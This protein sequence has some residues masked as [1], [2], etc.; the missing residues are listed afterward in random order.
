MRKIVLLLLSSFSVVVIQAQVL[1]NFHDTSIVSQEINFS[2]FA[3]YGAT[4]AQNQLIDKF[5]FGGEITNDIKDQSLNK[6]DRINRIGVS[7]LAEFEYINYNI[8]PIKKKDW[9][10]II[11]AGTGVF[12]GVF[13]SKDL[14]QLGMY[15]NASFDKP[16]IDLTGTTIDISVFQK[17]GFGMIDRKSKSRIAI[18]L[19]NISRNHKLTTRDASLT[20]SE[21]ESQLVLQADGTFSTRGNKV[22][23]QGLGLGLDLDFRIPI[24]N[25]KG[26]TSFVQIKA[27]NMGVGFIYQKQKTYKLDNEFTY[28]GFRFEELL[29]ENGIFSESSTTSVLD[30]IGVEQGEKT[31][32]IALPGYLQI[33]KIVDEH[34][35]K[36][37][38]SFFGLRVHPTSTYLPYLFAGAHFKAARWFDVGLNL[39]YGGFSELRG[40]VYTAF[41][42]EKLKFA[43][44]TED[45]LGLAWKKGRGRSL[46]FSLKCAF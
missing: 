34:S 28:Q 46:Y 42:F 35:P 1:T 39:G 11:K 10:M 17:I 38:Q 5:L 45:L 27:V 4:S 7:A 21:D 19:F 12:G 30:T 14:F 31:R 25:R 37:V 3:D 13:Y 20:T 43:I 22:F 26:N 6:H 24:K 8:K 33:G 29:G 23:N 16:T 44:G 18:N 2:G 36:K 9:G 32:V 40:G 15:G 41:K